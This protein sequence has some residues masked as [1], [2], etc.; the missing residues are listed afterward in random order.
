M[1]T[2]HCVCMSHKLS[3]MVFM[4]LG[5]APLRHSGRCSAA[6]GNTVVRIVLTLGPEDMLRTPALYTIVLLKVQKLASYK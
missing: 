2:V 6:A 3:V 1:L 5:V 4:V